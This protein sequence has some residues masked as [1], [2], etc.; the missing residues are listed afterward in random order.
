[1]PRAHLVHGF[2]IFD[3]GK[4]TIAKLE[5]YFREHDLDVHIYSYGWLGLMGVFFLNPRV[6]EKLL[7]QVAPGDI[8]IGHSNGCLI[9]HMAA[10]YGAPFRKV[11]YINPALTSK[12]PLADHVDGVDVWHNDGDHVVKF[13]TWLRVLFPW[14]PLGDPLWG[15]M[16]ARGFQSSKYEDCSYKPTH[17]VSK[18]IHWINIFCIKHPNILFVLRLLFF[19]LG[20][21]YWIFIGPLEFLFTVLINNYWIKAET[22]NVSLAN[23][24]DFRYFLYAFLGPVFVWAVIFAAWKYVT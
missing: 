12:V 14:A 11:S 20:F 8:A 1:M 17:G 18:I 2:N 24:H 21:A 15:D 16:G 6:V 4:K 23:A 22:A 10:R 13:A 19:P 9:I 7:P 5:P 3:E